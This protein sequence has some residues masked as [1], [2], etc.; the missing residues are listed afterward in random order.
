LTFKAYSICQLYKKDSSYAGVTLTDGG[1]TL[2][3]NSAREFPY[4]LDAASLYD[5]ECAYNILKVPGFVKAQIGSTRAIDGMRKATW[6]K[7]SSFWTFHPDNG[8]D[9]SF[10]SK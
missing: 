6:G 9:I 1:K 3:F 2:S 7:I 4:S 8:T 5:L 10:N